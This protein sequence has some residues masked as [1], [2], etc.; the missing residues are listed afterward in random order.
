MSVFFDLPEEKVLFRTAYFFVVAD[1]FPVAPGH[2]MLISNRPCTD[3]FGLSPVEQAALPEAI[4]RA[5]SW[6]E[7]HHQPDGYN[8][9]MNC[10]E[11]ASQTVMHF[12][13]HV[14]SKRCS[15]LWPQQRHP[16]R[17]SRKSLR[18]ERAAL[19]PDV[20]P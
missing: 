3:W 16:H 4:A 12:H 5:K 7:Q 8:I 9:G 11:A 1:G 14:W 13:C 18:P 2:V 15:T 10:G 6:I 17:K 19:C 20:W